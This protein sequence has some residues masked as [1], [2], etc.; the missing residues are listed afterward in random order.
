MRPADRARLSL[1]GVAVGDA[2]GETFFTT[3]ENI[4]RM[5]STRTP[6]PGTWRWTDDTA[7]ATSIV[8]EL[9]ANGSIDEDRLARRFAARYM[10]EPVRGYGRGA[11]TVL[12]DIA[13][14]EPWQRAAT[15]LFGGTGSFG[16]GAAMRAAPIG[17]FF[18]GELEMVVRQATASAIV[19]HSH[20]EGVAGAIAVALAAAIATTT[21]GGP[22]DHRQFFDQILALTPPGATRD[23]IDA[24]S[25]LGLESN[26]AH[27]AA[28]LGNG[29]R[30]S[31]V[32]TVPFVLWSFASRP[33]DLEDALW[34]TATALGDR[35]T[36]SA[37][38]GGIGILRNGIDSVPPVWLAAVEPLPS[39]DVRAP[40]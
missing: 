28:T 1:T 33:D 23:G 9:V 35:D 40:S 30:V 21:V 37:M 3:H 29:R 11:A 4:E 16:N 12:Q 7:M 27:A 13:A 18:A 24:A 20:E 19:T 39:L 5:V 25:R 38:V 34:R 8:E 22:F 10:K 17:A 36:T 26:V 32:D 6:A 15:R 31:A 2:F 14:G